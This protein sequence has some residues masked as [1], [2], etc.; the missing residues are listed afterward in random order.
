MVNSICHTYFKKEIPLSKIHEFKADL[1]NPT[2]YLAEPN[3]IFNILGVNVKNTSRKESLK[4]L[5]CRTSI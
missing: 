1:K 3:L 4:N 5:L 2:I